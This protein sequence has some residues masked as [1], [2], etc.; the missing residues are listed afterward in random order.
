MAVTPNT[1]APVQI[2]SMGGLGEIGKNTWAFRYEDEILMLD[3]GLS[4]PSEDMLGVNIVLPD[5]TWLR[6]NQNKIVGM[7]VTHGHEDHIGGI[8]YHLQ[9]LTIPHIWGPRLAMALL[10]SK[11]KETGLLGKVGITRVGSRDRVRVGR[12][13]EVEYIH[14]THSIADSYTLAIRTPAGVII[15]S[16]DFKFDHTPVD[17]RKFDYHRLAEYGEE[18]VLC[19]ISDSTNAELAG[20]TPSERSVY[21]NLDRAFSEA[22]DGRIILTTFASSIHRVNMVLQLAQKHQRVVAVLGRSMLNVIATAKQLGF[23]S[24]PEDLLQSLNVCNKLPDENVLILTTGSQGEPLAALTRIARGEH[25]QL[26]IRKG[27]TVMFSANPIPGNTIA[28]VRTIDKLMELGANVIYGKERGIHVSGHGSQEDHKL[29]LAL[30]KPKF[31]FPAHGELRM[32]RRHAQTAMAMGVPEENIV[33]ASNGDVIA[34]NNHSIKIVDKIPSG[35][36]LL[37]NSRLGIVDRDV[38]KDRQRLAEEGLVNVALAVNEMGHVLANPAVQVRGV[39]RTPGMKN[40]EAEV[41]QEVVNA[42]HTHWHNCTRSAEGGTAVDWDALR[43]KLVKAIQF[44]LKAHVPGQ[45]LVLVQ[46]QTPTVQSTRVHAEFKV[47]V[48]PV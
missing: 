44:K 43:H 16:G 25:K 28:V 31:F 20:F 13:F 8:P 2:M 10:E 36:E 41:G 47:P 26:S 17:G 48:A 21:P 38:L 9:R 29:M 12:H 27:D 1:T 11:L 7:V 30:T 42:L 5:M 4:F 46:L 22:R 14:N 39:G 45:P 3:G 15:H 40:L 33:I 32:L 6:E 19:L 18:G 35:I 37:D 34:V 24:Y 23:I